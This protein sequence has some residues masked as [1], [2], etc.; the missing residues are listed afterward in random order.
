MLSKLLFILLL[1]QAI[2]VCGYAQH[3]TK[4]DVDFQNISFKQ[5]VSEIESRTAF[6]F[7]YEQELL[8][9]IN[10]TISAKGITVTELL[11][12]IFL[13]TEFKFSI[14]KDNQVYITK[15][16]Q[17]QTEL[18]PEFFNRNPGKKS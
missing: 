9:S 8:D 4:L 14:D 3:Q 10:I 13:N 6:Y 5:F 15:N 16:Q 2:C 11:E 12:K 18:H 17:I 1:A 7:F